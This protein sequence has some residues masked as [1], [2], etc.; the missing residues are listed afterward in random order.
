MSYLDTL[1]DEEEEQQAVGASAAEVQM[2]AYLAAQAEGIE[3]AGDI[4]G[5]S[6][7]GVSGFKEE[8]EELVSSFSTRF[9]EGLFET[10]DPIGWW[11]EKATLNAMNQVV[12]YLGYTAGAI[13]TAVPNPIAKTLG[14]VVNTATFASQYN[15]NF[16]D[17]LQEHEERAGRPLTD[18]EKTWAA[19]VSGGVV[20]LDRLVPSRL[21]K[22]V[23]KKMGGVKGIKAA[24]KSI[25]E[26]MNQARSSLGSSLA[27]G[28]KYVGAKTG[29]EAATEAAQKSLQIATSKDPMHL[30]TEPGLESVVEEAA[31]AGPTAGIISTPGATLEATSVNRDIAR[32]RRQAEQFNELQ[33][34]KAAE[35]QA[36]TGIDTQ[37]DLIEIPEAAE[38]ILTKGAKALEKR[39][40]FDISKLGTK[41][42][43]IAAYKPGTAILQARNR[44]TSGESRNI[45]NKMLQSVTPVGTGSGEAK[46]VDATFDQLKDDY[47]GRLYNDINQTLLKYAPPKPGQLTQ[48][49][50]SKDQNDYI[51]AVLDNRKLLGTRNDLIAKADMQKIIS[52]VDDA[53]RLL[54]EKAGTGFIE[55]YLHKPVSQEAVTA[56]KDAFIKSLLDSSKLV[57]DDAKKKGKSTA[58]LIYQEDPQVARQNAELIA[59]DIIQ[60]RDPNVV[61]S[62]HLK[63]TVERKGVGQQSFEKSRSKEW[64]NL[65]DAFREQD[66]G[67]VLEQYAS[68]AATRVASAETFG[69]DAKSLQKDL[70]LLRDKGDITQ[71]ESDR[72]WDIY[73]ALHG[74]YKR[75]VSEGERQWRLASKGLT[76]VGAITH[77]GMATLSSLPEL[78]WVGER[79]G[80]G[81][82]LR[83]LPAALDYTRKGVKQGL[84]GKHLDQ[85]EGNKTLANL[86]FNLNPMMNERLD[87]LFATDRNQILSMYF[88]SPFGAFLTQW[89]NFN[90][91]WAAQA[92]MMMMNRRAKGLLN[93]SIDT[94]DKRRLMNELK[95]NGISLSEFQQLANLSKDAQG[96][97]NINF[98][99]DNYL[100][101]KFTKD[102]GTVTDVRSVLHP[103]LHKIVTDVV[104]QP[105]ATN[106]PLWM[107]DPSL[108]TI[109]QL[110]TFPIVFGNT[111][112]KRLLRKIR[113]K[114]QCT[115][116]MGLALSVVG[117]IAAA[118]AVAYIGEGLKSAI[119]G[120]EKDQ[121]WIDLGNTAGLFGA[122][123]LL[124]GAKYGDLTTSGLG[125]T[126]DAVF[127]TTMSDV[128]GPFLDPELTLGA[129]AIKSS[130]NLIDWTQSGIISSLGI[131]GKL[132]FE[133]EK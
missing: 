98:I 122:G 68:K 23:V 34:Q 38:S 110:K 49:K 119:R 41:A 9:P 118:M 111:V 51:R 7:P 28:A 64:A 50:L 86:G 22:D 43:D 129:G 40:G 97:I 107:S 10:E 112:V 3:A 90:R 21:G 30:F 125:P 128:I 92:G 130:D 35:L 36:Q 65:S 99:D 56:N 74:V 39:T 72:M 16:A 45:L 46:V 2:P 73:D 113:Q 8:Q 101:K 105:I 19:V 114:N 15:A 84:S 18:R 6:I 83:T 62:K 59:D 78:V 87:Q 13:L 58:H 132:L 102:N 126:L 88:R 79:A 127:N 115:P 57:Y 26:R 29:T 103:W 14:A 53:G 54:Q 33:K 17:T 106:K 104:I 131:P 11:E 70:N 81:N 121:S 37:A 124:V 48:P 31:V 5:V 61:T 60:G 63:D 91:N 123:G 67:K 94:M 66:I 20:A 75:D 133:E 120:Q 89:T 77:L 100:N 82:M 24:Q 85:S 25:I 27:T 42:L 44:Q 109:A 108:S 95:E 96:N 69:V 47:H 116:D 4:F 117:S 1:F 93:N 12:P 71:D 55:N 80:F 32:A 52:R 76:T